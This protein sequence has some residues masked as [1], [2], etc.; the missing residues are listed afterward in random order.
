[1]RMTTVVES[2][3]AMTFENV[4]VFDALIP[5][6]SLAL[7]DESTTHQDGIESLVSWIVMK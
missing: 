7:E 2:E 3:P 4:Q 1:V 5:L 6:V